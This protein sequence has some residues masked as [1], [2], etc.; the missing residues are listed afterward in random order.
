MFVTNL[1]VDYT[2]NSMMDIFSS[3]QMKCVRAKLLTDDQGKSKCAGFIDFASSDDA[4]SAVKFAN[5]MNVD[6]GKRLNVQLK[7]Q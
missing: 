7:K 5:N 3:T 4:Q 2:E 1:P 6:G